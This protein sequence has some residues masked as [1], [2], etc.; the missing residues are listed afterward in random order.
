MIGEDELII[1]ANRN[2]SIEFEMKYI[3]MMHYFLVM[4]VWKSADGIFLGQEK[5]AL[6]I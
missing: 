4:E 3:G 6:T 1:Y 2:L 5:Y